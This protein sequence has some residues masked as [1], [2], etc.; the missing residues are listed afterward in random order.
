MRRFLFSLVVALP[1]AAASTFAQD[2]PG[3]DAFEAGSGRVWF[4]GCQFEADRYVTCKNAAPGILEAI[5]NPGDGTPGLALQTYVSDVFI[6]KGCAFEAPP[7]SFRVN[8]VFLSFDSKAASQIRCKGK[9]SKLV[10]GP[11]A[12]TLLDTLYF[13][14]GDPPQ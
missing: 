3:K 9:P 2:I 5:A 12:I 14:A 6:E 7:E 1:F 11:D 4:S 10:F 8:G 13:L